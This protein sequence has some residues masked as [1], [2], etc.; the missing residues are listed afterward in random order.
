MR[1]PLQ[2]EAIRKAGDEAAQEAAFQQH[3]SLK[4]VPFHPVPLCVAV[5]DRTY[6]HDSAS[7]RDGWLMRK[8]SRSNMD[9]RQW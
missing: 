9:S 1:G 2:W 8:V 3:W 5:L 7:S 4:E 6:R